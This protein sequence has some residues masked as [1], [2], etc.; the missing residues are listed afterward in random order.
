M[1]YYNYTP[2]K[3]F[4]SIDNCIYASFSTQNHLEKHLEA[5]AFIPLHRVV[6][7]LILTAKPA[8]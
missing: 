6:F 7:E 1:L 2:L 3:V 8:F 5:F 4:S